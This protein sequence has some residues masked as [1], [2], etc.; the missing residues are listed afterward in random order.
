MKKV[1]FCNVAYMKNYCGSMND[2][3]KNGGKYIAEYNDGG[4]CYNFFDYNGK[5]YG[6]FMH[7]GDKLNIDRIEGC[8]VK[9]DFVD[10]VLVV[11][12]AKPDNKPNVI[13]GWYKNARVYRRSKNDF[14][15]CTFGYYPEPD[16][17][18]YYDMEADAKDCFLLPE[19][20]RDFKVPRA[21]VAG[22][23]KGMGQSAV[24]YA[25]SEYAEKEFIPKVLEYI[26]HYE[27]TDGEF[28]NEVFT[29]EMLNKSYEGSKT[30][31]ELIELAKNS[32]TPAYEAL[33]YINTVIKSQNNNDTQ[34]IKADIL[35]E[36][37]RFN[38]AVTIYE[39]LYEEESDNEKL[40]NSL[41]CMYLLTKQYEKAAVL[42]Q[43]IEKTNFFQTYDNDTKLCLYHNMILCLAEIHKLVK[44]EEY[45][46]KII[47][48]KN[49]NNHEEI[50]ALESVIEFHKSKYY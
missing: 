49:D 45:L 29:D 1:I 43:M 14:S 30:T 35:S 28:V 44:A 21:S 15:C 50:E 38:Q 42:G 10:D 18:L 2:T 39:N 41:F 46:N 4:E 27:N 47:D 33:A 19:A 48:M 37:Y 3:P 17:D 36:L 24:W 31:D 9:N 6:Y 20:K 32:D 8:K 7:Y 40:S 23:G 26:K 5:C 22:P 11:W 25:D 13:V 16:K 12:V 34:F